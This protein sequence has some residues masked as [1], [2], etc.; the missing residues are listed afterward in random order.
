MYCD[1]F[2][3]SMP[4]RTCKASQRLAN[5]A[6]RLILEDEQSIFLLDDISISRMIVCGKC[7]RSNVDPKRAKKAFRVSVSTLAEKINRYDEWGFNP[8]MT[9]EHRL[10]T[11]RNYRKKKER[12]ITERSQ[13][14]R[15][16]RRIEQLK[17]QI[18]GPKNES[19]S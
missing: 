8:E 2:A 12:E 15:I 11:G 14:Q 6:I 1:S 7:S 5:E 10:E 17:R 18:G 16:D 13:G 19:T 3:C 9:Q 4:I